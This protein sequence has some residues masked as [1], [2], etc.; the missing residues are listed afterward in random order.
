MSNYIKFLRNKKAL[1][2]GARK[3]KNA[4]KK[5]NTKIRSQSRKLELVGE[6]KFDA[7][8]VSAENAR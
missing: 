4:L 3:R 8:V 6:T 1:G 7:V 5:L 2:A